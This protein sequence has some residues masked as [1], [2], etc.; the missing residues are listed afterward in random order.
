MDG[1]E[2][3]S[4]DYSVLYIVWDT[5]RVDAFSGVDMVLGGARDAEQDWRRQGSRSK[6]LL[7]DT[8][9]SNPGSKLDSRVSKKAD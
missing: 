8:I 5:D 1:D 2:A 4:Q 7:G 6:D 9:R 3:T